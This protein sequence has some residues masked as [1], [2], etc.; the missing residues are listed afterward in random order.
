MNNV[1]IRSSIHDCVVAHPRFAVHGSLIG[2]P[3]RA[4]RALTYTPIN[5][6]DAANC[7]P[8]R[9]NHDNIYILSRMPLQYLLHLL[10]KRKI[11]ICV[12]TAYV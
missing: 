9:L 11:D 2:R 8:P 1:Y 6:H 12:L 4:S 10:A 3:S 5:G 7:H